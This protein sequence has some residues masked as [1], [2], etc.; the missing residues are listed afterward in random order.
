[1]PATKSQPAADKR[2]LITDDELRQL[3]A[4]GINPAKPYPPRALNTLR[5]YATWWRR[6]KSDGGTTKLPIPADK[7]GD[8]LEQLAA[9]YPKSTCGLAYQA[10]RYV[11]GARDLPVPDCT[12]RIDRIRRH[13]TPAEPKRATGLRGTHLRQIQHTDTRPEIIALIALMRNAMLRRG[14][15]EATQTRHLEQRPDGSGLLYIPWSKTD[16]R[17]TGARLDIA[18]YTMRLIAA[19]GLLERPA[20]AQLIPLTARNINANIKAAAAKAKL[21]GRY[22]GH[23]PRIG[24]AQDL[25]AAGKSILEIQLAG[26][27][28]SPAMVEIYTRLEGTAENS[29]NDYFESNPDG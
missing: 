22:T 15:M 19:A 7:L 9:E 6:W 28:R 3:E 1:M 18:P 20:K 13:R 16:Q 23:S 29:I 25:R 24:M 5:A 8:W 26:R 2:T 14:E 10:I 27:W 4:L 11:H 21:P 17:G 12:Y